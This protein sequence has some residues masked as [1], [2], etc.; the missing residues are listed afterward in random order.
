MPQFA[1]HRDSGCRRRTIGRTGKSGTPSPEVAPLQMFRTTFTND[2]TCSPRSYKLHDGDILWPGDGARF[3]GDVLELAMN[4][5][6]GKA[7]RGVT[8]IVISSLL[9]R[10]STCLCIGSKFRCMRSTPTETQSISENDVKCLA[11][12]GVNTPGT[13]FPNSRP[14][15]SLDLPI[16]DFWSGATSRLPFIHTN[17]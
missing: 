14:P 10:V 6:R 12:T 11:S 1:P 15:V 16:V 2:S 7:A 3:H 5:P 8:P 13:M 17:S 4:L 9:C